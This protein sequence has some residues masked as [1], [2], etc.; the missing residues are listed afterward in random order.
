MDKAPMEQRVYGLRTKANAG[1]GNSDFRHN[2][3]IGNGTKG[4]NRQSGSTN[5]ERGSFQSRQ[6]D[7]SENTTKVHLYVFHDSLTERFPSMVPPESMN[8]PTASQKAPPPT[9]FFGD[10]DGLINDAP[11]RWPASTL[12]AGLPTGTRFM[13]EGSHRSTAETLH[14]GQPV[15]RLTLFTTKK[16]SLIGWGQPMLRA[17]RSACPQADVDHNKETVPHRLGTADATCM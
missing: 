13:T 12:R 5:R 14:V 4:Q 9:L 7:E 10:S 8:H 11:R 6:Q 15:P 17:C 2:R 16:Q 3:K 1:S